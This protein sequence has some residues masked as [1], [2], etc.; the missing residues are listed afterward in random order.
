VTH[1]RSPLALR[2]EQISSPMN[3]SR[4]ALRRVSESCHHTATIHFSAPLLAGIA[5]TAWNTYLLRQYSSPPPAA[6]RHRLNSRPP[7]EGSIN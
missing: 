7:L 1:R 6:A 5:A 3:R 4:T 2:P